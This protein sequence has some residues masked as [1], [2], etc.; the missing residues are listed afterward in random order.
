M[1]FQSYGRDN[2]WEVR[3]LR[4]EL[5]ER[6]EELEEAKREIQRL[7]RTRQLEVLLEEGAT[8]EGHLGRV[9]NMRINDRDFGSEPPRSWDEK[10]QAIAAWE[11]FPEHE[12][13]IG[14]VPGYRERVFI[15][16]VTDSSR[17]EATEMS[18]AGFDSLSASE[19]GE[20]IRKLIQGEIPPGGFIPVD[21]MN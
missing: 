11:E 2:P 15:R 18:D 20:L 3:A 10:R 19:L 13:L 4:R 5:Q 16:V 17:P 8:L 6:K 12:L 14:W 1:A 9:R 7:Q 21:P